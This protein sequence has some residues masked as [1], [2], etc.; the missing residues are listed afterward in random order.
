MSRQLEFKSTEA[1]KSARRRDRFIPCP[2]CGSP[3][4]RYLFHRTGARFV[5]CRACD[6]VYADPVDTSTRGYFDIAALGTHD[7]TVDR[8]NILHDFRLMLEGLATSYRAHVGRKPGSVLVLGRWHHDFA[9]SGVD[10]KVELASEIV[11]DEERLLTAPIVES[12]S[13]HIGQFDI[14]LFNEFLEAT[15]DP[16]LVLQGLAEHLGPN[17]IVAVAFSNTDSLASRIMRRRWKG[18]FD[19][20]IGYYSADNLELLLWRCGFRRVSRD[21]V[22][23]TYSPG[24]LAARLQAPANIRTALTTSRLA[25]A[26][27]RMSSGHE[28]IAFAPESATAHTDKL[29]IIVPVYNEERYVGDVIRAL[30]DRE[31]PVEREIVVV[32]SNSTD[33]SRDIVRSFER[34]PGVRVLLEDRPRGKGHAVRVALAEV[35]GTI[36]LIQDADFEYDLDDYEALLEPI[37]QHQASFVLGSRSLGLDD[38][39]VRQYADSRV[40]GFLMN[41]AQIAF[42][43]TFNI[44]YRQ[45]VTD[46]NTML[47]V[48]RRECI[49]G[50]DFRGDGFNFDIELVCKIVRNG[51]NPF[52]VPVNYVARGFDE[53]KKIN[54]LTDAYP[55]YYQLWKCRLGP[56]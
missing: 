22:Y 19:H 30:L 10:V 45:K 15:P 39:K 17:T 54:F 52:E 49:D 24:Y 40:K 27:V 34:E 16:T 46:I 1:V 3:Q 47:K 28:V 21:R 56:L 4:Q 51:F 37:L 9:T 38:W 44:L 7:A 48:F 12:L 42:A 29:S 53:G 13:D 11:D 5:R 33:S 32:E 2:A 31:L 26:S 18:F 14:L 35:T 43:K 55:S 8:E 20:K 25:H 41:I 50:C 23:T 36:V 6:L